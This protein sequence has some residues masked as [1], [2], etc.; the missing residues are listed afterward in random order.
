MNIPMT[1]I[2]PLNLFDYLSQ[3]DNQSY[4]CYGTC[5]KYTFLVVKK[6]I[7]RLPFK[8]FDRKTAESIAFDELVFT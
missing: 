7:P 5:P 4:P 8:V 2:Y 1:N 3:F 6:V